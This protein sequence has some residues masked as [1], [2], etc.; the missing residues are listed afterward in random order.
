[1]RFSHLKGQATVI[2]RIKQAWTENP[3]TLESRTVNYASARITHPED[4]RSPLASTR[5]RDKLAFGKTRARGLVL[6]FVLPCL[7]AS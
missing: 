3:V 6:T 1:M 4:I 7:S 5:T 2:G